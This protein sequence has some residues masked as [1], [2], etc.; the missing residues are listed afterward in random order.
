MSSGGADDPR[1]RI[2]RLYRTESRRVLATLIRLLGDFDLAEE[3]L[4]DA[5]MA[6]AERWPRDGVPANPRAWLISAGRFK[7]IDRLRRRA[8]F[9]A[10]LGELAARLD[11][12]VAADP[13]DQDDQTLEDDR[14]RLVFTCCHPAL[15][16][17]AQVAMTLREVCGLT[18]EEI[19]RAFLTGPPTVAQRIVRAKAKIRA[20]GIPYEVPPPEELP[21]RLDTVLA[22][23][24]LV[25]TEGYAPASGDAVVRADLADEAIRL[26]RLLAELLPEPEVLGLLALM[27]LQ[28]A[29]RA[30]RTAGGTDLVLLGDQD[31]SRW[32]QARVAEGAALLGRAASSGRVGPYALQAAIAATHAGAATAEAT[33]WDR[34]VG[35]YDRLASVDPSPVVELNRAAAISVRDGPASGLALVDALLDGGQLGSYPLAH[36]TRADL[37]RRLGRTADA[38]A[39]Y[40]RALALTRHEPERRFLR[41]RLEELAAGPA[42]DPAPERRR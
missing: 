33:D 39:A 30:A 32:D 9:D 23:V 38:R 34:I 6:A 12:R 40:E 26:G 1:A 2:D 16:P 8:R 27:L 29:R 18:T 41:Q 11:D 24:Y 21:E 14:L 17:D 28:D 7:A 37:L 19:A 22:V 25:F 10:V 3:A 4:Q 35:L 31:R 13:A 36:A 5:F 20:A 15:P 42:G